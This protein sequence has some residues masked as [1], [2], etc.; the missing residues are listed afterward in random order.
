VLI[1]P[2]HQKIFE[3]AKP[4]L[5]TRKNLIHTRIALHYALKLLKSEKGD[6]DVVIP[7]VLLHDVG[8]KMIPG[9][10]HLTAFGPNKSNPKL[11][12][13]HEV[14]G[15][16]IAEAILKDLQYPSE[17]IKG[18]SRIIRGHDTRKKPIS[19]NDRIVKD[20]DKLWRY[21]RK[22][23]AIDLARFRIPRLEYLIF[24]EAIIDDWFLTPTGRKVA[25]REIS[26]RKR[27]GDGLRG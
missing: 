8:W 22:G 18:I 6:E 3:K 15:A 1:K 24:L 20:A 7:A 19:L 21:S 12:R 16:K 14:E 23:T 25:R 9:N 5:R 2:I 10:L 17:K 13:V 11:T 26:L 27:R 4:F